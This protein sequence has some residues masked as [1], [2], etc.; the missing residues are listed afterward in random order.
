MGLLTAHKSIALENREVTTPVLTESDLHNLACAK[1]YG[2][3][4]IMQPF[5]RGKE[6]LLAIHRSLESIHFPCKIYAKIEN[7]QGLENLDEILP[8]CDCVVI[9]RGDLAI[10]GLCEI[11]SVQHR[12]EQICKERNHPYMVV[13]Q[14][15]NSMIDNPLPTRAEINDIYHSVLDGASGIMLTAET[16]VGKLSRASYVYFCTSSE[17]CEKRCKKAKEERKCLF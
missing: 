10:D 1:E 3:T 16:A 6:D 8:Y 4:G 17:N 12:I 14:M 15:L 9:A 7:T 2:V 11:A 5:V 13:T